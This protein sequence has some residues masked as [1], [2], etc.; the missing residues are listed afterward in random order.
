MTDILALQ[1]DV[2]RAIAKQVQIQ[3]TA[4][5][6]VRLSNS[7]KVNPEAHDAYLRGR[8]YWNKD[9]RED[10]ERARNYFEEALKKDPLYAPAH[11]GLA[12]YYS[13]L[14]FYTNARP[15]DVFP[16]A[17]ESVARALQ[18]DNSLAEAHGTRAYILTY[19]DWNWAEA[20]VEFQQALALNPNDATLRHRYSRYLSV[21]DA[22]TKP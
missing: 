21:W 19:Y 20:E 4:Q 3:L 8:F 11:A 5:E 6:T 13:V 9:A 22:L 10:L 12:D 2:A 15:D 18:I 17:K 1:S 14:P 7:A 16:K